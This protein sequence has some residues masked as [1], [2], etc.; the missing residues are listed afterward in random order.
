MKHRKGYKF[1]KVVLGG[2]IQIAFPF[3]LIGKEK[4]QP[5]AKVLCGNHYRLWDIVHMA[6]VTK[7]PVHFV[8]KDELY[9][10]RFLKFFCDVVEAIPVARDGRD[11]KAV[12][13]ALRYLKA[14]ETISLFPEGG[15]NYSEEELMPLKG[16]SAMFAIKG[17][18]P[19]YPVM[20]LHKTTLFRRTK[21]I[22]GDPVDLSMY[23]GKRMTAQDYEDAE[24][25]IRQAMLSTKHNYLDEQKRIREEKR[26]K[27]QAKKRGKKTKDGSEA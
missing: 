27:K 26:A 10:S 13:S 9:K 16:G 20:C 1:L 5:G 6:Y 7:D 23:Y 24:E 15:R 17:K 25:L 12:M 22:I 18:C 4:V 21:I 11:V 3:K 19:V 8:T 14:G 2:F